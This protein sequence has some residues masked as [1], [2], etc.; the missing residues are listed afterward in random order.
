MTT[1]ILKNN[2]ECAGSYPA[3]LC[4]NKLVTLL[5]MVRFYADKFIRIMELLR[6]LE[7]RCSR[8]EILRE[9]G[10]R[11]DEGWG[12]MVRPEAEELLQELAK[13]LGEAHLPVATR[14]I[15]DL[16]SRLEQQDRFHSTDVRALHDNVV[17]ELSDPVFLVLPSDRKEMF[18]NPVK[19][20]EVIIRAF[21]DSQEDIE[22]MNKCFALSRYTA[23]VFHSL[24]VV[25]HG[26]IKLGQYLGVTD[27]KP[28]WD[29]TYKRLDWLAN[30]RGAVPIGIAFAFIEQAKARVE[31]MKLAWRNK[32]NHAA[33]RLM[34]EKTGFSDIS[35]EEVIIA[36]RSFMRQLAEGLPQG[37][38]EVGKGS[39]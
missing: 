38:Y 13:E 36:S 10:R 29:A 27:P 8:N 24:L 15:D 11:R 19:G 20:W 28:G 9:G 16:L 33:G 21:P 32:V 14:H 1:R 5:E 22:E 34:V 17:R 6:E 3:Q 39:L 37:A 2:G 4:A 25:E 7:G 23:A 31:S 18:A 35:A 26:L 12:E 30:N